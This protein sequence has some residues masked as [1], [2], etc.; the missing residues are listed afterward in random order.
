MCVNPWV[1]VYSF[2]YEKLISL[3]H[4]D[5]NFP[6]ETFC[7][8][9]HFLWY[10]DRLK[11]DEKHGQTA[12]ARLRARWVFR[13]NAPRNIWKFQTRMTFCHHFLPLVSFQNC[14]TNCMRIY[15][16]MCSVRF[17]HIGLSR[18]KNDKWK[19]SIH[20]KSIIFKSSAIQKYFV[21]SKHQ[22]S[23]YYLIKILPSA[24]VKS[25]LDQIW[26]FSQVW[27]WCQ[28]WLQQNGK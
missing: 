4:Q 11:P 6:D 9:Q 15:C 10:A 18:S 24:V 21:W 28:F 7:L 25:H 3:Y 27:C 26:S 22:N 19:W 2:W 13:Y 1:N 17:L 20:F 8:V 12:A 23:S 16:T 5:S 14:M